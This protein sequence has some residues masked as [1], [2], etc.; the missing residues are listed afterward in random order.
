MPGRSRHSS[1]GR[2]STT[3]AESGQR[4]T[5]GCRLQTSN[6]P[7][8]VVIG[9]GLRRERRAQAR[10]A[11]GRDRAGPATRA[12][13]AGPKPAGRRP[14]GRGVDGL[15]AAQARQR[16]PGAGLGVATTAVG[17]RSPRRRRL[18]RPWRGHHRG[19][20]RRR[21]PFRLTTCS[22]A[23]D[24][25]RHLPGAD[26]RCPRPD[27]ARV[28]APAR[29]HQRLPHRQPHERI[30]DGGGLAVGATDTLD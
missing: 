16:R 9:Q 8:R 21:R 15:G 2:P 4:F 26:A 5:C 22:P 27:L 14:S 19:R 3:V 28:V 7:L 20:A 1:S 24:R 17:S 11:Q 13:G 18:G 12:S 30:D 10:A 29:S 25:P 6:R 23:E